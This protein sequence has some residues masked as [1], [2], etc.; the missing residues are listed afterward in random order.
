M[1]LNERTE[2]GLMP[3]YTEVEAKGISFNDHRCLNWPGGRTYSS[4]ESTFD[5]VFRAKSTETS[6][7]FRVT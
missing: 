6:M 1:E 2:K 4:T 3:P 7:G 5:F